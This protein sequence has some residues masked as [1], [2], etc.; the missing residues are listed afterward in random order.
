M[1]ERT[2]RIGGTLGVRSAAGEGTEI[3]LTAPYS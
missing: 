2:A 3:A 1:R